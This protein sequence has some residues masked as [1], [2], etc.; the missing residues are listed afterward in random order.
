MGTVSAKIENNL[1]ANLENYN[2]LRVS[3]GD[4]FEK[5]DEAEKVRSYR[6][7]E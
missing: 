2:M 5:A 6:E 1:H 4:F 3:F 7:T